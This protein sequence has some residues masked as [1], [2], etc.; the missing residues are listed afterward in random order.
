MRDRLTEK[1]AD[2]ISVARV[3]RLA[4]VGSA[5]MPHVVPI[6]HILDEGLIVFATPVTSVKA[7]NMAAEPQ[8]SLVFDDYTEFWED[9]A[10]VVVQGRA[11]MITAGPEFRRYRDLIYAKFPQ[12]PTAADG[13]SEEEDAMVMVSVERVASDGL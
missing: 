9:L 2:F 10:Q 3:G 5:G 11:G 13:I 12:Y 1:E 6:C 4:T 7:R 8:V